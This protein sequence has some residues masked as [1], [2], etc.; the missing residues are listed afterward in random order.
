MTTYSRPSAQRI[1]WTLPLFISLFSAVFI[2]LVSF[3]TAPEDFSFFRSAP[4]IDSS[5]ETKEEILR[6]IENK[7]VEEVDIELLRTMSIDSMLEFLDPHSVFIP[8]DELQN[9]VEQMNGKFEGI[10]IEFIELGDTFGIT[11]IVDE[12]PAMQA[13]LKV[14]DQIIGI[15]DTL[16]NSVNWETEERM[17]RFRGEGKTDVKLILATNSNQNSEVIITR[18][19]VNVQTVPVFYMIDSITAFI[20][21][22]KFTG[23]TYNEFMTAIETLSKDQVVKNLILDL[24]SNPGGYLQQA[25]NILSQLFTE[26]GKLLVSTSG[27]KSKRTEYKSTGKNFYKMDEIAVLVDPQSASASEIVAGTIQDLDRGVI[28]GQRTFGKGMVQEQFQLKDGSGLRLTIAYYNLP[29]G[30]IIHDLGKGN[31]G[32]ARKGS[33]FDNSIEF[34]THKGR[35]MM[36]GAGIEPDYTT[37]GFS[38]WKDTTEMHPAYAFQKTAFRYFVNNKTAVNTS[39]KDSLGQLGKLLLS[40]FK[41]E[42]NEFIAKEWTEEENFTAENQ[43][44]GSLIALQKGMKEKYLFTNQSDE[45][46]LLAIQKIYESDPLA[47]KSLKGQN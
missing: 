12:S 28:I 33:K 36:Q 5:E 6:Y 40:N 11:R 41:S 32:I 15:N 43:L 44:I 8:G 47:L 39:G 30:R 19:T 7:Y 46:V 18:G 24:R 31:S 2:L 21:I 17:K 35:T 42:F 38:F 1:H 10:G 9:I 34:K 26:K 22:D 16:F 25:V 29:S 13:G 4:V 20:K 45:S 27:R 37:A 23:T 14:G 3:W